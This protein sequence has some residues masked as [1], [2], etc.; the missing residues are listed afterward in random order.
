MMG[1]VTGC[2]ADDPLVQRLA[3]A[4]EATAN[5]MVLVTQPDLAAAALVSMRVG[6][7][8]EQADWWARTGQ[9]RVTGW[10][11]DTIGSDSAVNMW[12]AACVMHA[13]IAADLPVDDDHEVDIADWAALAVA[14]DAGR[15][16]VPLSQSFG[17]DELGG[18]D[19]AGA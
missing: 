1:G 13:S 4:V 9:V 5:P 7:S 12:A 11:N 2:P 17:Q 3:A 14:W 15:R 16:D 18:F 10:L 8:Q 6:V 19:D